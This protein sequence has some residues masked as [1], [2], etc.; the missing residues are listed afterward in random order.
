MKKILEILA[1]LIMLT[2]CNRQKDKILEINKFPVEQTLIGKT[3]ENITFYSKG[4]AKLVVVD[5]FLAIQKM[6][7]SLFSIF[8][9]SDYKL[10]AK[11]GNV[12]M[13]PNEFLSPRLLNQTSFDI[14]NNSP[15]ICIYDITRRHFVRINI[16]NAIKNQTNNTYKEL[17]IPDYHQPFTY[18]FYRD[19]DIMVATPE[20]NSRLIIYND[21]ARSYQEASYM[22]TLNYETPDLFEIGKFASA[23][24]VN[25]KLERIVSALFLIGE[26]DFFD[27][28]GK[29]I[30]SSVFESKADLKKS[31]LNKDSENKWNPK[32]YIQDIQ[33]S[34]KYI[35]ALNYD[36]YQNDYVF[37]KKCTNQNILVFDWNGNPIKKYIL[38]TEH[39]IRNFAVDFNNKRFYGFCLEEAEHPIIFYNY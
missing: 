14:S 23:T 13:G 29:F 15:V 17:P 4:N 32:I 38:D 24:F 9:T 7:E 26:I 11:F 8:S 25:K 33:A 2:S 16:L 36:N 20:R 35:Y 37:G 10:M 5:T 3:F 18:F 1:L 19:S 22:P 28:N 30:K 6:D 34:D 12:G 27:L 31:L 21:S 39:F